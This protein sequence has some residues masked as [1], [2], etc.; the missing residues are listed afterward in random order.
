MK[1]SGKSDAEDDRP[2]GGDSTMSTQTRLITADEF[3]AWPDEPG[4]RQEL[5][6][7]EVV[8]MSLPGWRHGEVA[9]KIGRLIGNYVEA[10]ELGKTYAAE[11]G[12]IVE[13]D[14]DTVRGPD[15]AF[16]R[17]ER[18]ADD[19]QARETHPVRTRP[20]RRGDLAQRRRRRGRGKGPDV[21]QGRQSTGL[22][23]RSREP[24]G[25]RLSARMPS[26]S[27]SAKTRRSMAAT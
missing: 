4:F 5:I 11:T 16:V 18:L 12:F 13:R 15:V 8:T 21:A 24:D 22:D 9:L 10:S 26:P 27:L 17:T 1:R 2:A 7:G 20:G 14:P 19:H 3:L 6:R 23:G 25:H